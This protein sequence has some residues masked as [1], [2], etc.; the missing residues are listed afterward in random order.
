MARPSEGSSDKVLHAKGLEETRADRSETA[1]TSSWISVDD[2][3]RVR[4]SK[5][6]K[7]I[8]EKGLETDLTKSPGNLLSVYTSFEIRN[9]LNRL[10]NLKV[11]YLFLK[12]ANS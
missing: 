2:E 8:N 11:L 1:S 12:L 9:Y 10:S 6:E 5:K 7:F 4:K 3:I